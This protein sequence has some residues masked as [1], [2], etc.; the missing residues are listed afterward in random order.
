M[1]AMRRA[2][3]RQATWRQVQAL[4]LAVVVVWAGAGCKDGGKKG[5]NGGSG[6]A[7][8][9]PTIKANIHVM[10]SAYKDNPAL[11]EKDF[12]NKTI[13]VVGGRAETIGTEKDGYT[14]LMIPDEE[15]G[16]QAIFHF[17]KDSQTKIA[18]LQRGNWIIIDGHCK[19]GVPLHFTNCS[20]AA[21]GAEAKPNSPEW[22]K[23]EPIK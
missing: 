14:I 2:T 6:T 3:W 11:A 5:D 18:G 1:R 8:A 15:R 20:I 4:A 21:T 10:L 9:K 23:T 22:T 12:T 16:A 17:S 13:R 7:N 19:G